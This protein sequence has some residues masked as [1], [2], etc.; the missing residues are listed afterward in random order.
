M[1]KLVKEQVVAEITGQALQTL[2][3]DRC[4]GKGFPYIRLGGSIRYD[5]DDV[6]QYIQRNRIAPGVETR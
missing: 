3:N 1:R 6:E 4:V 2:R 5:L